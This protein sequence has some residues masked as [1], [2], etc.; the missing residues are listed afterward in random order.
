M[1]LAIKII[2]FV[3]LALGILQL[4]FQLTSYSKMAAGYGLTLGNILFQEGAITEVLSKLVIVVG[5]FGVLLALSILIE[6]FFP[7][8]ENEGSG[9]YVASNLTSEA[10]E[11]AEEIEEAEE[12]AEDAEEEAAEEIEEAEEAA[13]DAEEE[14]AEEIEEAE[15]AAEDAEEEAAEEIEEVEEAAEETEEA[16]EKDEE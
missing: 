13:E 11:A 8:D 14:A 4:I 9:K 5:F 3:E 1:K 10:E 6:K 12:A 16:E 15:E 2:A 7:A